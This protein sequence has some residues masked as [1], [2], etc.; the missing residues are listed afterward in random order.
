[1]IKSICKALHFPEIN[2]RHNTKASFLGSIEITKSV[3][4]AF[5][6]IK[7]GL[8]ISDLFTLKIQTIFSRVPNICID[9]SCLGRIAYLDISKKTKKLVE[10]LAYMFVEKE[11]PGSFC[12]CFSWLNGFWE[13]P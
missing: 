2:W 11:I 5:H 10:D 8:L 9:L 6:W 1:M 12:F 7:H 4:I 13:I 3:K